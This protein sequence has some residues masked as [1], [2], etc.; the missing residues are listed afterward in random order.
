M[1][2][3]TTGVSTPPEAAADSRP[4]SPEHLA[5]AGEITDLIFKFA[6]L[7]QAATAVLYEL[8]VEA[9]AYMLAAGDETVAM[10]DAFLSRV[11]AERTNRPRPPAIDPDSITVPDLSLPSPPQIYAELQQAL[12]SDRAGAADLAAI[13]SKD[14]SLAAKLLKTVNSAFFALPVKVD[15]LSRAVTVLGTKELASLSSGIAIMGSFK[16]IP[17]AFIDMP[18]FWR[19]SL[20]AGTLARLLAEAAGFRESERFFVAGLLHDLGRLVLFKSA[21]EVIRRAILAAREEQDILH[22]KEQDEIGYDHAT[23]GSIMLRKWNLPLDLRQIVLHHHAPEIAENLKPVALIHLADI[24]AR[25]LGLG[26]SGEYFV[27]PVNEAA[28]ASLEIEPQALR[29]IAAEAREKLTPLFVSV[30]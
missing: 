20:A 8:G 16:D 28:W 1:S 11:P 14:T 17:K 27:P 25:A 18:S 22:Y 6:D 30:I 24:M 15:T 21:P 4:I 26:I 7:S 29:E 12:A 3:Q 9:R 2:R 23:I 5:R 13:V 19:H 10:E